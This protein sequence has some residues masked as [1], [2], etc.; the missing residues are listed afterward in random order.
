VCADSSFMC[1]IPDPGVRESLERTDTFVDSDELPNTRQAICQIQDESLV[2]TC[3]FVYGGEEVTLLRVPC[4]TVRKIDYV[5]V[6]IIYGSKAP[7]TKEI[8]AALLFCLPPFLSLALS[9]CFERSLIR[10]Q[11]YLLLAVIIFPIGMAIGMIMGFNRQNMAE[12]SPFAQFTL[13]DGEKSLFAFQVPDEDRQ[14][15]QSLLE[16]HCKNLV[17][18]ARGQ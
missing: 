5:R 12:V 15:V 13:G 16:Q 17:F 10:W 7:I 8:F 14:R 2:I 3:R 6:N 9:T 18:D 4:N 1:R 11:I